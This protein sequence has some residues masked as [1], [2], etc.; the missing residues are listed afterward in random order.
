MSLFPIVHD[1]GPIYAETLHQGHF[2]VEPWNA[3][4]S[5][6]IVFPAIFWAIKLHGHYKE[7]IFLAACLPFL[8][9]GGIGS[10]IFHGFRASDIW[11]AMDVLPAAM[12]TLIASYYFW[13]RLTKRK[14]LSAL[15]MLGFLGLRMLTFQF[16][17]GSMGVNVSYFISGVM[18]FVPIIFY[19]R[20]IHYQYSRYFLW[21]VFYLALSLF[22]RETDKASWVPFE[23]GTHFLWHIFSGVGAFYLAAFIYSIERIPQRETS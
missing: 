14:G 20:L 3:Y 13:F 21:S 18:I 17:Q 15:I 12:V 4:S 19:L 23:M 22:F 9:L 10:A 11:L 16:L 5:L 2:L 7:H 1:H 8:F 6:L